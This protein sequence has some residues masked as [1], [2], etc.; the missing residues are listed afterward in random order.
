[1]L[2]QGRRPGLPIQECDARSGFAGHTLMGRLYGS[3]GARP[4]PEGLAALDRVAMP[5][6]FGHAPLGTLEYPRISSVPGRLTI[7]PWMDSHA[8]DRASWEAFQCNTLFE[9]FPSALHLDD[10]NKRLAFLI[11]YQSVSFFVQRNEV[12]LEVCGI[13][14]DANDDSGKNPIHTSVIHGVRMMSMRRWNQKPHR[15]DHGKHRKHP[16][17]YHGDFMGMHCRSSVTRP[18]FL[19]ETQIKLLF[20]PV[21]IFFKKLFPD[22]CPRPVK[23]IRH[24]VLDDLPRRNLRRKSIDGVKRAGTFGPCETACGTP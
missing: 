4:R 24:P 8:D 23:H 12:K 10:P 16:G 11:A 2:V 15:Q 19:F 14:D 13:G 1:M 18:Y 5:T 21:H 20:G 7:P 6:L 9:C 3:L 22:L 17:L